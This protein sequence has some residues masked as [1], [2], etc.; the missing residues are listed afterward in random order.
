MKFGIL[1]SGC[2]FY[3]GSEVAESVL[4]A[5]SLERAG[6]KPVYIAP[7]MP[8]LHTIEHLSGSEADAEARNVLSE[9]ARLARGK[10]R[11]LEEQF[12]GELVGLVIP[13]GHGTVKNLMTNFAELGKKREL[14]PGVRGLLEDLTSRK[15]PIGS[16]SLARAVIQ[17]FHG[18]PLTPDDMRMDATQVEVDE[19]RRLAFTPGFLTATSLVDVAAGIDKMVRA[20]LGLQGHSLR[21][22]H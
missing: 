2:G 7:E 10:I 4:S 19:A 17:T 20:L 16:I 1:L 21:V 3:D 15:A 11:S 5:L 14:V 12:P 18:E 8:Q 13:G 9:S 6:M 22:I